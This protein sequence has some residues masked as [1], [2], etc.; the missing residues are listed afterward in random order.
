MD[1]IDYIHEFHPYDPLFVVPVAASVLLFWKHRESTFS[2]LGRLLASVT[3][4]ALATVLIMAV[5][6]G[7]W[8][9]IGLTFGFIAVLYLPICLIVGAIT[10]VAGKGG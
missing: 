9:L 5:M 2:F 7:P 10:S 1:V 3:A 6:T 4:S 8:P